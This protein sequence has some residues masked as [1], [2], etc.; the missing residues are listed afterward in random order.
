MA[1]TALRGESIEREPV[2][3]IQDLQRYVGALQTSQI[4]ATTLSSCCGGKGSGRGA[5]PGV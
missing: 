3:D 4:L 5:F 2:R 1:V